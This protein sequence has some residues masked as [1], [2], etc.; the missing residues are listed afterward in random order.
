MVRLTKVALVLL[1]L[2][3]VIQAAEQTCPADKAAKAGYDAFGAFHTVVA[4]VWHN[5]YPEKNYDSMLAAAPGFV[6]AMEGIAA[7]EPKMKNVQRKGAFLMNREILAKC[8]KRY[9]LA[10]T[11]GQKDSVYAI[12]P[13]LHESFEK[14]ASAYMPTPYPE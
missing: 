8:V 2:A 3:C 7:L 5:F 4:P 9:S 1:V 11:A 6:K 14:C 12:V 10:A 13:I